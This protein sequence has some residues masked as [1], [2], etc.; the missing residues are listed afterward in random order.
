M[1]TQD[2]V[3]HILHQAEVKVENGQIVLS[4]RMEWS[5]PLPRHDQNLPHHLEQQVETVGQALKRQLFRLLLE[6]ADADAVLAARNGKEGQGIQS[7]GTRPYSFKT[8]FG[9][10]MIKRRRVSQRSDQQMTV[11]SAQAWQTPP[12][13][14]ITQGLR[15]EVCDAMRDLS[16]RH[17]HECLDAQAA[18]QDLV[19][20]STIVG[21]VHE[22]GKQLLAAQRQRAEDILRCYPE[23]AAQLLPETDSAADMA[24][25][26]AEAAPVVE[27][28]PPEEA[29]QAAVGFVGAPAAEAVA[30]DEARQVDKDSVLL[31]VDEVKTKA[32][33]HCEVKAQFVYT[34]VLLVGDQRYYLAEATPQRLWQQVA[35]LLCLLGVCAGKRRLLLLADGAAWIRLWFEHIAVPGKCM[36]LCW[37]H[38]AEK[39]YQ[40]LSA[41]GCN[42]ERRQA[43]EKEILGHLWEGRLDDALTV[44]SRCREEMRQPKFIDD[45][46]QYLAKR[47]PYLPNYK[48]R[49]AAGLWI[50]SNRVEKWNDWAVSQRCKHQGMSWTDAGVMA[51]ASLQAARYNNELEDWRRDR[52]L[53]PWSLESFPL[54]A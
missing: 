20:D 4:G 26:D 39:C 18:E 28:V 9:T 49:Q 2:D 10:V 42:K 34:G 54:A 11:P 35:A 19:G 51:L 23:A 12:R 31:Q 33:A 6:R 44:L 36:I 45:L 41:A 1:R 15:D 21:I 17:T 13:Q 7:R 14:C 43:L 48:Q 22:E 29:W 52:N 24:K 8:R 32:Q 27:E 40:R 30:E 37:F 38:L 46:M 47:R 3:Q 16:V 50:A 25:E 5:L 53:A